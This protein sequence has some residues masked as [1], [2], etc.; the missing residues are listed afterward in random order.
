MTK[1]LHTVVPSLRRILD[2]ERSN[3]ADGELLEAFLHDRDQNA[4]E[5][6]VRR[7]GPRILS[8]CRRIVGE[9][10][11]DDAFQVV[12]LTLARKGGLL[13]KRQSVA[14]W[15][16]RVAQHVAVRARA[17]EQRRRQVEGTMGKP[18]ETR[19]P[20]GAESREVV[21]VIEAELAELPEKYRAVL[22]LCGVEEKTHDEAARLLGLPKGSMSKRLARGRDLLRRRLARQGVAL[23]AG[24]LASACATDV[25]HALVPDALLQTTVRHSLP[26]ALGRTLQQATAHLS[27]NVA[28]LF[29]ETLPTMLS[30]KNK[31]WLLLL[32][33]AL[34]TAAT[35]VSLA[36]VRG[37]HSDD[38]SRSDSP[39]PSVARASG[40]SS[41]FS[42]GS[43]SSN[44][45]P[46]SSSQP[47]DSSSA[48]NPKPLLDSKGDELPLGAVAR[49]G[50]A[51]LRQSQFAS[52]VA[53]S[54]DGKLLAVGTSPNIA[55]FGGL[56]HIWDA[57]SGKQVQRLEGHARAISAVRFTADGKHV[58]SSSWDGTLR[59]WDV[60]TGKEEGILKGQQPS[61]LCFA[62]TSDGK[63]L[64][65]GGSDGLVHVWDMESG[66]ETLTLAKQKG[67]ITGIDLSADD[68]QLVTTSSDGAVKLWDL[69]KLEQPMSL[70]LAK[71]QT[72]DMPLFAS[73]GKLVY[74]GYAAE[75]GFE[76]HI[77]GVKAWDVKT[78]KEVQD[79]HLAT[80]G[81]GSEGCAYALAPGGKLAAF[82]HLQQFHDTVIKIFK[83]SSGEEV[84]SF[85]IKE[86]RIKALSF[87]PDGKTIAAVGEDQ[88]TRLLDVATGKPVHKPE[89][90]AGR[91]MDLG[92]TPDGKYI[93][94]ASFD[95]S[96]RLFD[97]ETGKELAAIED[98]YVSY[99]DCVAVRPDGKVVCTFMKGMVI[100]SLAD[101]KKGKSSPVK[102][103]FDRV[104][105]GINP[106]AITRDGKLYA[107]TNGD[108]VR[109][110]E[111]G[112]GVERDGIPLPKNKPGPD[113][114][115][116]NLS[117]S[118]DNRFLAGRCRED[119]TVRIWDVE[120]A[121]EVGKA[122]NMAAFGPLQFSPDGWSLLSSEPNNEIRLLE[123][124][125]GQERWKFLNTHLNGSLALDFS[126]NGALIAVGFGDGAIGIYSA[127][128]GE[129]LRTITTVHGRID[130]LRFSPDGKRLASGGYDSTILVWDVSEQA[131]PVERTE[132]KLDKAE[133]AQLWRDL[134]DI[135]PRKGYEAITRLVSTSDGFVDYLKETRKP[136]TS[137]DAKVIA[138]HIADLDSDDEKTQDQAAR[139][140]QEIGEPAVQPL[141]KI[142]DGD[143]SADQRIKAQQVIDAIASAA[144]VRPLRVVEILERIGTKNAIETLEAVAKDDQA[145]AVVQEAMWALQRLR[146]K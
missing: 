110:W 25:A 44:V 32:A 45:T 116:M 88:L 85:S 143:G 112:T 125:S 48:E 18:P 67:L 75:K 97:A 65:S 57:G 94:S 12:F 118:P 17:R 37:K 106:G 136:P 141:K 105:G 126:P 2:P 137:I 43:N 122:K 6:L 50:S 87:S 61:A 130:V 59:L 140:L 7:H 132:T 123:R 68:S 115:P 100:A 135:T 109:L 95:R 77:E 120:T 92:Y 111:C 89:G 10:G 90:P 91:I 104:F 29:K 3:L 64:Y 51:R 19:T 35:G 101:L 46:A 36:L 108:R 96:L 71:G 113:M 31:L 58:V 102:R 53:F 73:S 107:L 114:W 103:E 14:A 40:S 134:A 9:T 78:G 82:A 56:I 79:Y 30:T 8:L 49:M 5:A 84:R 23:S 139:E 144:A 63:T 121:K 72:P 74:G 145:P 119:K 54:R 4:F 24:S 41:Q 99:P 33:V 98:I 47:A 60:T 83:L 81:R 80:G 117:F 13:R 21:A 22:L 131:K 128:T 146:K 66:A 34:L 62:I 133:L 86:S 52:C 39:A 138:K 76:R 16:Y 142:V 11:A 124:C 28:E 129:E 70:E 55:P 20:E 38:A 69:N 26:V 27:A 15:L 127:A 42:P 93:V 1:Q